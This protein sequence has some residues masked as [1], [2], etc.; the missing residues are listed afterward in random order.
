[1]EAIM[2]VLAIYVGIPAGAMALYLGI[3]YYFD[4]TTM[5]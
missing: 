1:M 3:E 2:L 5:R 4:R